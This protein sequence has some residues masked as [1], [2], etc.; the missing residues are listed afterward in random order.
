VIA[1]QEVIATAEETPPKVVNLMEALRQ[2]LDRVSSGK[3]ERAVA[4]SRVA[5][6]G[7]GGEPDV[8]AVH[9]RDDVAD[10]GKGDEPAGDQARHRP[11]FG[12]VRTTAVV[13]P[14]R[15]R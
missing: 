12:P 8:D 10:K 11:L 4:Q 3:S 15:A 14:A 5:L 13:M 1:G 6:Q 2:S 9:I 7:G